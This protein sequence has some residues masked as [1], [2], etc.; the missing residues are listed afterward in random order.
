M[1]KT[2]AFS[3]VMCLMVF[4]IA[5]CSNTASVG[6]D[7]PAPTPNASTAQDALDQL[8]DDDGE[9]NVSYVG[10][11][12]PQLNE[13]WF[14]GV[15]E[16][17]VSTLEA[18]GVKVESAS[19]DN[20]HARQLEIVENF[21]E[22]GVDGLILFPI[23][24]SEIG[25]TLEEL[26]AKGVRVIVFVNSVDKG[27]DG[28][29]VTNYAEQG[30]ACAKMAA[31]WID[32]TFPDAAPGSIEVGILSVR[33]SP[34]SD[35]VSTGMNTITE[36]TDKAKVVVEYEAT[37]SDAQ[38]KSQENTELMLTSYPDIKCILSYNHP[39]SVDEVIMR[40]PGIDLNTFAIFS[41]TFDP[42]VNERI[43]MSRTNESVIRGCTAAGTGSYEYVAEAM[44]GKVEFDEN[45]IFYDPISTITA[46]NVDDY[47]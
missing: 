42:A 41:N 16:D 24:A 9:F 21:G 11:C 15:Q 35:A 33:T 30:A 2:L 10:I 20:D 14:V 28:M 31:E 39:L 7:S 45:N 29:L 17:I 34:E 1:K 36:Y 4:L 13:P 40:T 3:L 6:S 43:A 8:K 23:G 27:Y 26:Q 18:A 47:S 37:F 12:F 19:C 25:S 32:K 5:G 38:T 44:L 46:D 22:K